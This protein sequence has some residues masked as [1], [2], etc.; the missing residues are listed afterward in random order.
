MKRYTSEGAGLRLPSLTPG[1]LQNG[2]PSKW[3]ADDDWRFFRPHL[4][5]GRSPEQNDQR[6]RSGD[7]M[8][9]CVHVIPLCCQFDVPPQA[10]GQLNAAILFSALAE[11]MSL[12]RQLETA[13][14]AIAQ[15]GYRRQETCF[16]VDR[17][18]SRITAV[19]VG[20]IQ[21]VCVL[22]ER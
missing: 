14:K 20:R 17:V 9:D 13:G 4:A 5:S 3:I 8:L 21:F 2:G 11:K 15:F 18:E 10:G 19:E 6:R 22:V 16:H 1:G 7:E 12:L